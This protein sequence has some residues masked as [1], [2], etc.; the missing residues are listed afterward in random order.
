MKQA[1][2]NY[3][4]QW[5]GQ[6][7]VAHELTRRGYLVA[8]TTGNAPRV[9]LL[10]QSPSRVPFSVQVKS[11]SSKTV[12]LFQKSLLEARPECFL[13][14][15]HVPDAIKKP[16]EYFVLTNEQFRRVAE[17]EEQHAMEDEKKGGG[18]WTMPGITY[19]RLAGHPELRDAWASLPE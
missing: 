14:F 15:V 16:A 6:F 12:F 10:C 7:G 5:A 17:E 8:F 9:D 11:L 3:K 18:T 1:R 13:V 19:R 4:T 2:K